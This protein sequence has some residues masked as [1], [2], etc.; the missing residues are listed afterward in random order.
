MKSE[1]GSDYEDSCA[2]SDKKSSKSTGAPRKPRAPRPKL[3]KWSDADW[4]QAVLAIVHACGE[5]GVQ[6]PFDAAAKTVNPNCTGGALQQAILKL[7]VKQMAEGHE[8]PVLK[9]AWAKGDGE[10]SASSSKMNASKV[11]NTLGNAAKVVYRKAPRMPTADAFTKTHIVK[12]K[13]NP[14]KNVTRRKAGVLHK[15]DAFVKQEEPHLPLQTSVEPF[16]SG[17]RAFLHHAPPDDTIS[18]P[19]TP[20]DGMDWLDS[21]RSLSDIEDEGDDN[22]YDEARKRIKVPVSENDLLDIE[23]DPFCPN[24]FDRACTAGGR[25]YNPFEHGTESFHEDF[26]VRD[27]ILDEQAGE[28]TDEQMDARGYEQMNAFDY[29]YIEN[30]SYEQMDPG[31]YEQIDI[32]DYVQIDPRD[33]DQATAN[34]YMGEAYYPHGPPVRTAEHPAAFPAHLGNRINRHTGIPFLDRNEIISEIGPIADIIREAE[35]GGFPDPRNSYGIGNEANDGNQYDLNSFNIGG[36]G[37]YY[38]GPS[39]N[40]HFTVFNDS[41]VT[42]RDWATAP[43]GVPRP[44]RYVPQSPSGGY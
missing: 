32:R 20:T 34:S 43:A 35:M 8:V 37:I 6:I 3:M 5:K 16:D 31:D 27:G 10:T 38:P 36:N 42:T 40:D 12:L 15:A 22:D 17:P 18:P 26:R 39:A 11:G 23:F 19:K 7:R 2:P 25:T 33:Y 44:P 30:S 9:M 13:T 14:N 41:E 28:Q 24:T 1:S 21:K 4:K 29:G